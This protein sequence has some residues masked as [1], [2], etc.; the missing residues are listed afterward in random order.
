MSP[1]YAASRLTLGMR[2]FRSAPGVRAYESGRKA[3]PESPHVCYAKRTPT[4]GHATPRSD[5]E[6]TQH[7]YPLKTPVRT[8]RRTTRSGSIAMV[9]ALSPALSATASLMAYLY[10]SASLAL[11]ARAITSYWLLAPEAAAT[12]GREAVAGAIKKAAA[13]SAPAKKRTLRS[14]P[15]ERNARGPCVWP[16]FVKL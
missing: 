8:W 13:K 6:A 2:A 3:K 15:A 12:N 5:D 10:T 9:L 16:A 1:G 7:S 4:A 11:I 14:P